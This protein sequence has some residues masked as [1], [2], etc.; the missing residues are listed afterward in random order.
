GPAGC[1]PYV[2]TRHELPARLS[3]HEA[4]HIAELV[5][6]V[7]GA[8]EIREGASHTEILLTESGPRLLECHTRPGGDHITDMYQQCTGIDLVELAI[9]GPL[10]L[11]TPPPAPQQ[12][13]HGAAMLYF[14]PPPGRLTAVTGLE[15]S[16]N[17][18]GVVLLSLGCRPGA[19]V[20]ELKSSSDRIGYVMA[21]GP[22]SQAATATCQ[23]VEQ[24]VKI[25]VHPRPAV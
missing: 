20:A 4:R 2:E 13:A 8:L 25:E 5:E 24:L 7:L 19:E 12:F 15:R 14:T 23:R 9:G 21:I 16:A 1:N 18:P 6:A 22:N 11:C 17:L 3:E 10:G